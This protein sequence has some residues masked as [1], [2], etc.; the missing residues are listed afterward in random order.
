M[1]PLPSQIAAYIEASNNQDPAGVARCFVADAIVDDDGT[2][3]RG[4]AEIAAWAQHSVERYRA[5]IDP[6]SIV[7]IDGLR[8]LHASVSGN[9]PGSP[10]M[11]EFRFALQPDGIGA[12]EVRV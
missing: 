5:T 2:V 8:V 4:N 9:F 11:L 12:L 3:K 7:D 10:T 1:I 6:R